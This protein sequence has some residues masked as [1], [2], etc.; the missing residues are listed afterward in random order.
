MTRNQLWGEPQRG[1]KSLS[2]RQIL[3]RGLKA[4]ISSEPTLSTK[5]DTLYRLLS[6][7]IADST[8]SAFLLI[9]TDYR[10]QWVSDAARK[11]LFK[12]V[13]DIEGM[14]CARGLRGRIC[15]AEC[16]EEVRLP[17]GEA[18]PFGAACLKEVFGEFSL[19]NSLMD[20]DGKT[21]GL[22]KQITS[23]ADTLHHSKTDEFE[24]RGS[25]H[26]TLAP[27]LARIAETT[28]PILLVGETGTGKEV[29]AQRIHE[30]SPRKNN[31]FIILDLSVVPESLVDDALFGHTRGAFTG[32]TSDYTGKLLQADGGTL[33]IDELENIPLSVQAKL[34]RFLETGIVERIGQTK[35]HAI[36]VRIL[37]AT[38]VS[39]EELLSSG[40]LREDL[41]YRLRGMT[42]LLPPLRE[43][44]EEIPLLI[45]TFRG[46]WSARHRR[47]A[48]DFSQDL[49]G[50]FCDY[51][52]PGNIR[53]LKHM[54]DL[55]LSLTVDQTVT[56]DNMPDP[57]RDILV[58]KPN[59]GH[60]INE[61]V[62]SRSSKNVEE[63]IAAVE[64][65][66][67]QRVLLQ[68]RG[69]VSDAAQSLSMSRI[70]RWRKMKKY[71]LDR[72]KTFP[73]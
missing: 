51:P 38:N 15:S 65:D 56:V 31:P 26:S 20:S 16:I 42:I 28:I 1:F 71:K 29:L 69:R 70:T 52:F 45:Q 13:P 8:N 5:Q 61:P 48:P 37:A 66:M 14:S 53:E 59:D 10:I 23:T 44:R 2:L 64:K 40:R 9:G 36:D 7:H 58:K 46:N 3:S 22:L 63:A 32:A 19:K 67:I 73:S 50:R 25:W 6:N 30:L 54:V 27:T 57:V 47:K 43:R 49:V 21:V 55:C 72:R 11:L 4:L 24:S 12:N 41:F 62:L 18:T 68:H 39:P 60:S 33:L 17:N 34:L 35:K